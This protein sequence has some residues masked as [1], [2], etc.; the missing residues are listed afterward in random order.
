MGRLLKKKPAIKKKKSVDNQ[1]GVTTVEAEPNDSQEKAKLV[2][3][4]DASKKQ[5]IIQKKISIPPKPTLP[6]VGERNIIQ[7]SVQFLREVKA[8]LKKVVWPTRKQTIGSTI[9][10]I[11]LV[12]IVSFFLGFVDIGL[13]S[14]V[15]V[16]LQK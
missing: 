11:I 5:P 4:E 8:E 12:I 6:P 16:V 15:R 1:S 9:V 10:V 3:E 2:A 7:K 13:S 14:L